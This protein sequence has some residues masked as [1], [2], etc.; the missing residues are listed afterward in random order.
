MRLNLSITGVR[1]L[2]IAV[3]DDEEKIRNQIRKLILK[4]LANCQVDVY[5]SGMELIEAK[6]DYDAIF[7]D[8]QMEGLSGIDTAKEL[9]KYN[10][11]VV[12]IFVD[13]A[14]DYVL[15]AFDVAAFHYLLKPINEEKFIEVF[16]KAVKE[17]EK[18]KSSEVT[19]LF[20]KSKKHNMILDHKNILYIENRGRKLEIHTLGDVIEI[21]ATMREM[22]K[23]LGQGFFRCHRGYLVN[24]SFILEYTNDSISL[25]N[26]ESILM[27]KERYNDF[28]KMY[29]QYLKDEGASFV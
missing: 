18:H 4:Q 1:E 26:G 25:N 16:D 8:I 28:V 2:N 5:K 6:Q 21:Y 3:V 17:I 23:Q 27:A 9:R 12:I 13:V 7:L 20:V 19:Q 29:M 11:E 14:K 22:E 10:D 15:E 24:L